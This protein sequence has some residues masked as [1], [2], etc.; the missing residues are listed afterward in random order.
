MLGLDR[1]LAQRSINVGC[2][3]LLCGVPMLGREDIDK[4]YYR[5]SHHE[6]AF[7]TIHISLRSIGVHCCG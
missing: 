4:A 1:P 3:N 6:T 2:S 5:L 7:N